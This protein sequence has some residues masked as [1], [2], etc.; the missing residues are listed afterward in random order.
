MR[1]F[2]RNPNYF[3]VI[4][5]ESKAYIA[6]FIAA[7]GALVK[8]SN[9]TSYYLTITIKY[10]DKEVLE[11][12]RTELGSNHKLTEISRIGGYGKP[13]HHIRLALSNPQITQD[14][15]K[16]GILPNKSLSMSNIINNI[17][18]Q[19]RGAFIIGYFDGDGSV[20]HVHTSANNRSLN[21]QIRGTKEF[22]EGITT[23]IGMSSS[24]IHSH[25]SI[26]QLSITHKKF[27]RIFFSYYNNLKFYYTRKYNKFIGYL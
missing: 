16:L 12:I 13:V 25:G 21:I 10:E 3:N 6:G 26:P 19:F 24:Y 22:L 23:H 5:N 7:D 14:L 15:F 11:F 27:Q 1:A 18:E 4:D 2:L 20:S 17:P 9:S 8:S